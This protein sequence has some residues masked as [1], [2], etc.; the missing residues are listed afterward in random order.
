MPADDLAGIVF[1]KDFERLRRE[2][3]V[4]IGVAVNMEVKWA[5]Y[6][7]DTVRA[8][9]S[10]D[11][12]KTLPKVP[13]VFKRIEGDYRSDRGVRLRQLLN[14]GYTIDPRPGPEIDPDIRLIWKEIP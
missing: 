2:S 8:Q 1:E 9:H 12:R 10:V 6:K 7:K 5:R 14:V 4:V 3:P 13:D 11:L